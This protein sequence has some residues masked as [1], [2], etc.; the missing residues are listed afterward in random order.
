M[1]LKIAKFAQ[2]HEG[3]RPMSFRLVLAAAIVAGAAAIVPAALGDAVYHSEHLALTPVGDA[4]LRSGFVENIHA[5]GPNV[6]AHEVYVL[7]GALPNTSYAVTLLLHPNDPTCAGA[8]VPVPTAT[9]TTGVSGNGRADAVFDVATVDSFG[10]RHATHGII[11]TISGGGSTY[12]TSCT[13][14]TLD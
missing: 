12:M 13:A 6:Y 11:W 9:F 10:I 5:N 3:R 7:N 2:V 4:P 14:V 1:R 8:A